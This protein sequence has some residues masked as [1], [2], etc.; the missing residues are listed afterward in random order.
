MSTTPKAR[1]LIKTIATASDTAVTHATTADNPHLDSRVKKA[2]YED[3]EG[4]RMGQQELLGLILED[5]EGA[6]WT[7]DSIEHGRI[8][9]ASMPD[10][11]DRMVV[12]VDPAASEAG[13]EN[14]IVVGA[15]L[16]PHQWWAADRDLADRS[17]GF[18][19]ADD[20]KQGAP[21]VWAKQVIRSFTEW[22]ANFVVA[23]INNGGEM[24]THTMHTYDSSLPVKTVHASRG[25]AKRAEPV[26]A[27]YQQRR[28]HH[29]GMFPDLED[30]MCT[31]DSDDPDKSWS[32]DRMDAMVWAISALMVSQRQL[33]QSQANDYRLKG[34]R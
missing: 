13:D 31:W 17:H 20:S 27:L 1:R 7:P 18:I 8:N 2:L 14:G 16:G 12:G 28:I 22:E 25:K 10:Y 26:S 5:V 21:A 11:F 15:V 29:V 4:T 3:Y 24:V 19:L 6:L 30:Q 9:I 32:P 23:E 33:N 34:R